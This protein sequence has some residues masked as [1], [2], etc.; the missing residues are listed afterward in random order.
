MEKEREDSGV[1]SK[2]LTFE[3]V[4]V[5]DSALESLRDL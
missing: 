4:I 1:R 2:L 5:R 3:L